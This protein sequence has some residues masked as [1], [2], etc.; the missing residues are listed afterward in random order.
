[1]D[2]RLNTAGILKIACALFLASTIGSS[3]ASA[4]ANG[5]FAT[6]LDSGDTV[7]DISRGRLC[8]AEDLSAAGRGRPG[9]RFMVN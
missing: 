3:A 6:Q 4:N 2:I 1:M 9:M 7:I 8:N 5:C